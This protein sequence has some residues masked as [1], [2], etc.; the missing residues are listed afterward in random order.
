MLISPIREVTAKSPIS[1]KTA[2]HVKQ[3]ENP[4]DAPKKHLSDKKPK[5]ESL[6]EII[7]TETKTPRLEIIGEA[8]REEEMEL[9]H[10]KL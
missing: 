3:I 2:K 9:L 4:K 10:K 5:T 8:K 7:E 6:F 1:I